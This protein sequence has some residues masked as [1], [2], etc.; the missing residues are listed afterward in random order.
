[1][2]ELLIGILTF[3]VGFIISFLSTGFAG[4]GG[5]TAH[6]GMAIMTAI[7]YLSAIVATCTTLIIKSKR[8]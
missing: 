6:V 1:M 8:I 4:S 2:I 7:I 3:I 5:E